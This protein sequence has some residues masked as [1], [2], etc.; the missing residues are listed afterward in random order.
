MCLAYSNSGENMGTLKKKKPSNSFGI[1][2]FSHPALD[3]PLQ[4]LLRL[5]NPW[6]DPWV[7]HE[8][9]KSFCL[10]YHMRKTDDQPW[11]HM[12]VIFIYIW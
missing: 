7:R 1:L 5:Q 6:V 10:I 8:A 4:K 11:A 12:G 2:Q 9:F 3:Q